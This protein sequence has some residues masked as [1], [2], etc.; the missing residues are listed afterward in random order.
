MLKRLGKTVELVRFPDCS[1]LFLRSGH[2]RMRE[3]YL[4]RTLA[5]FNK[6]L[7]PTGINGPK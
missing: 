3:E 2:P 5:W 1:H 7:M 6:Y 4:A